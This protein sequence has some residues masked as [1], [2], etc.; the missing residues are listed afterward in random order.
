MK[1]ED[2][3]G[4]NLFIF[5]VFNS[6][7][8]IHF[9]WVLLPLCLFWTNIFH[10]KNGTNQLKWGHSIITFILRGEGGPLKC[11]RMQTGR[12][13]CHFSVSVGI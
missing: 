8:F 6:F 13:G 4:E 3:L 7:G 10:V 1:S 5:Y 12:E 11:K 2:Q 9:V